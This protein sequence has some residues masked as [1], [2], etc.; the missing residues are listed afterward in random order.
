MPICIDLARKPLPIV[1]MGRYGYRAIAIYLLRLITLIIH[2]AIKYNETRMKNKYTYKN[3]RR[4]VR[5]V[6]AATTA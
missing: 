4:K 6:H 1:R 2:I 5:S 3:R